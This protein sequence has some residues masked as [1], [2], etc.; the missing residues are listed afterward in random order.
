MTRS[1]DPRT[2]TPIHGLCLPARPRLLRP[3]RRGTALLRDEE[4]KRSQAAFDERPTLVKGRPEA[5]WEVGTAETLPEL[6]RHFGAPRKPDPA[7][8]AQGAVAAASEN[9]R[10][11]LAGALIGTLLGFLVLIGIWRLLPPLEP[12]VAIDMAAPR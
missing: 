5:A 7:P 1:S 2:R 3:T 11:I 9:Q 6:P 12:A 10:G 8:F 4:R